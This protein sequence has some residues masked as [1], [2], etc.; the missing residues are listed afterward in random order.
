MKRILLKSPREIALMRES[1]RIVAEVLALVGGAVR[2]GVPTADLDILAEE[3]I[4][5]Q[6]GEPAF[7]GYGHDKNNLFP[8]TLC[9]SLD[10]EVVHGFPSRTPL[11]EGQVVSID[12]G[13]L[14]SGFYGDG[15]MT[16]TVGRI[17]EEKRQLLRVTEEA[18]YKGIA[19]AR[20]GNHLY[21]ISAAVQHH[22]E[23]AGFSVVQDLVGHGVGRSLHE[24]PAVPNFGVRGTGVVL[25]EGM[26]LAIE[27]MVNAG[28]HRVKV[29][30]DG[31]TVRTADGKPSA[32][33]EHTVAI[34]NGEAEILT[35][36][37]Q[38]GSY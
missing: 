2:A 22:V 8:A 1:G 20:A 12:V 4:R 17:P 9:V 18:L 27:P 3:Y 14:K 23:A 24:E 11:E 5:A 26:V 35:R 38:T 28:T 32:H 36:Y 25:Q 15:A 16:F 19:Q 6:G 21:D 10:D 7:K 37:G 31:W 13:V 34:R 29:D 30:A 33:F